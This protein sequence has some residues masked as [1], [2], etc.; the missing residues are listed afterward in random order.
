MGQFVE[1]NAIIGGGARPTVGPVRGQEVL[2]V[3]VKCEIHSFTGSG[4]V[5]ADADCGDVIAALDEFDAERR[6]ARR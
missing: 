5:A 2:E 4:L 3:N 6:A 1:D